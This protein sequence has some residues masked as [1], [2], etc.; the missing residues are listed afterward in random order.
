M[1]LR[2]MDAEGLLPPRYLTSE[3]GREEPNPVTQRIENALRRAMD[4]IRTA[5][6]PTALARKIILDELQ[7]A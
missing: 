2:Q 5:R 1:V 7:G 3:A 4:R 6:K